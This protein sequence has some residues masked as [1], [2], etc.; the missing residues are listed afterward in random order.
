MLVLWVQVEYLCHCS[1]LQHSTTVMPISLP[2]LAGAWE[3]CTTEDLLLLVTGICL[4][5]QLW[6][7]DSYFGLLPIARGGGGGGGEPLKTKWGEGGI[8]LGP[9]WTG[10]SMGH[11][12]LVLN[13]PKPFL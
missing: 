6:C 10:S 11:H 3:G 13:L 7:R 8:G 9:D 1:Q 4:I 12:D 2:A 5:V